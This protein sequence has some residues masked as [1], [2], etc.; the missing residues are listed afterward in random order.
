MNSVDKVPI[1][2]LQQLMQEGEEKGFED[3]PLTEVL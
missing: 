2:T 3:T 1:K